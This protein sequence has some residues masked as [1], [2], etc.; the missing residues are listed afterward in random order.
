MHPVPDQLREFARVFD[1]VRTVCNEASER[2]LVV[3]DVLAPSRSAWDQD[4]P[5]AGVQCVE[6]HAGTRL[7]D[8]HPSPRIEVGETPSIHA[9]EG[10]CPRDLDARTAA[11]NDHF[12]V[13]G[14]IGC[15]LNESIKRKLVKSGDDENQRSLPTSLEPG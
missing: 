4:R 9:L 1:D 15:R 13:A 7:P 11:L 10:G 5:V 14:E 12:L 8:H 2:Q 3:I 6:Q